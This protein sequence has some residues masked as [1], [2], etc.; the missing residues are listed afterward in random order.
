M[1]LQQIRRDIACF[2]FTP[3]I[4]YLGLSTINTSQ[5]DF[6]ALHLHWFGSHNYSPI[7]QDYPSLNI[8]WSNF[9]P[10]KKQKFTEDLGL[11]SV[12]F[13]VISQPESK[14]ITFQGTW[15]LDHHI[16]AVTSHT[17]FKINGPSRCMIYVLY[18]V[19]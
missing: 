4:L 16:W 14:K 18:L 3:C 15:L 1:P 11:L 7:Y 13:L 17:I 19:S 2:F 10:F 9:L 5:H 12:N 8:E 6:D